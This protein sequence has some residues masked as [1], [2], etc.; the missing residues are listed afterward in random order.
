MK[1]KLGIEI[2]VDSVV[3]FGLEVYQVSINGTVIHEYLSRQLAMS[4]FVE[5]RQ[6]LTK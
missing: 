1:T 3:K 5:L 2:N 6:R 4:K